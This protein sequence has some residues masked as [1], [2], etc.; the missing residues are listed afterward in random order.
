MPNK[1]ALLFGRPFT[2][3]FDWLYSQIGIKYGIDYFSVSDFKKLNLHNHHDLVTRQYQ[4]LETSALQNNEFDT[5]D[6][7]ARC[8][9]LR[10]LNLSLAENLVNAYVQAIDELFSSCEI[11]HV[12]SVPVDNYATHLLF[13]YCQKHGIRF[14]TPQRSFAGSYTRLTSLGEYIKVR[15]VSDDEIRLL[16]KQLNTDFQPY[17]LNN[18]RSRAKL[19]QMYLRERVKK[20]VF[21]CL[22][23]LYRERYSFHFNTIYPHPYALT[24][25]DFESILSDQHFLGE[26]ESNE[27][28]DQGG[29]VWLV[30]QF[31]PETSLDYHIEDNR[32]SKYE[33][34]IKRIRKIYPDENIIAKEHPSCVGLRSAHFYRFLNSQ[35]IRVLAQGVNASEIISKA[36]YVITTGGSSTGAETLIKGKKLLNFGGAYYV[37]SCPTKDFPAVDQKEAFEFISQSPEDTCR[38]ILENTLVGKYDFFS[39]SKRSL[40]SEDWVIVEKIIKYVM[41]V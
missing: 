34:F 29:F 32:F 20:V 24:V 16:R 28:L 14:L 10:A 6:V 17:T 4:L 35:G 40:K 38:N 19:L 39:R 26:E 13:L 25:Y 21:T 9:Y 8:R 41:R 5:D 12:I 37:A 18:K 31:S 27:I 2:K 15:E 7:I 1:K 33:S 3:S 36:D 22:K 30:L 11:D 23:L